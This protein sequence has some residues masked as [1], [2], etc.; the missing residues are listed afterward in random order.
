MS[1]LDDMYPPTTSAV[2]GKLLREAFAAVCPGEPWKVRCLW[3][4]VCVCVCVCV[5]LIDNGIRSHSGLFIMRN[6][7]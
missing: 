6:A 3:K 1:I 4:W 7:S 5:M 2:K